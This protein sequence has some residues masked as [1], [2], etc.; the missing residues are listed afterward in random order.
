MTVSNFS[1]K[2]FF[3]SAGSKSAVASRVSPWLTPVVYPL[4]CRLVLPLYFRNLIVHGVEHIPTEGPVVLAPTHRARWD[5]LTVAYAAGRWATGRDLRFMVSANEVRG[6]QGWFIRRLGGFPVNPQNPAIASLRL[7]VE[8]LQNREM[9][10]IFPEGG[11]FRDRQVHPLKPGLARLALQAE[12]SQPGL[13]VQ[14]VP[15]SI[16]YGN[17]SVSYGCGMTIRIGAPLSAIDYAQGTPKE[18]A[19]QLTADLQHAIQSLD[20]GFL[21]PQPI[22]VNL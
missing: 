10:V 2:P 14:I 19:K 8:V 22:S 12:T 6:I 15:M 4:G 11:I 20:G 3:P 21:T 13:G 9:L 5:A 7:G 18:S 17:D 16:T 1:P